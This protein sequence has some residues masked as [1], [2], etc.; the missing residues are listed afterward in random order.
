MS[1]K[2]AQSASNAVKG[3]ISLS[4]IIVIALAILYYFNWDFEALFN[5]VFNVWNRLGEWLSQTSLFEWL[6]SQGK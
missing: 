4:I 1:S 5:W 6:G 2:V 3:F